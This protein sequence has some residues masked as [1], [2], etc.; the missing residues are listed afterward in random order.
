MKNLKLKVVNS[1]EI[2]SGGI[3][4]AMI[5]LSAWDINYK[6]TVKRPNVIQYNIDGVKGELNY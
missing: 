4:K 6:R 3:A 5:T 2:I 1:K